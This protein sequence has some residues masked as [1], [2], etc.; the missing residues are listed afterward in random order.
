MARHKSLEA[1]DIHIIYAFSFSNEAVRLS[2]TTN[3][4]TIS[5]IGKVA[6][7]IDNDTYYILIDT[8][9]TWSQ[10]D[11]GG[12]DT[13]LEMS[14]TPSTYTGQAGNV[15]QVNTGAT[16]VEFGQALRTIDSPTFTNLNLTGGIANLVGDFTI[17][18][19]SCL[20]VTSDSDLFL[21]SALGELDLDAITL[22]QITAASG[23]VRIRSQGTTTKI[24][25]TL[26][27]NTSATSFV[28]QDSLNVDLLTV[29]G[30]GKVGIGINSPS[31]KLHVVG[32]AIIS[33]NLTI[34]G[35]T[36]TIDTTTLLV[37]DKNIELGV[38]GTPTDVTADG[39]G[40]TLKGTTD[41]TIIW[42][43]VTDAWQFNQGV[44]VLNEMTIGALT[45]PPTDVSLNLADST[46]AFLVNS[47]TTA[48]RDAITAIEGM[49]YHNLDAN[50][51]EFYN[52]TV[53]QSMG[54]GD[55][56][57]PASSTDNA[58]V[59]FNGTTGKLIQENSGPPAVILDDSRNITGLNNIELTG[60]I[61]GNQ[62]NTVLD[63]V[64]AS[65]AVNNFKISNAITGNNPTIA[66]DGAD[67][68]VSMQFGI[69]GGGDFIFNGNVAI[70]IA[71][72]NTALHVFSDSEVALFESATLDGFV[73]IEASQTP[74][75]QLRTGAV[76]LKYKV[77]MTNTNSAGSYE[78][79]DF[80]N[81]R[82]VFHYDEA[83]SNVGINGQVSVGEDIFS[84][85]D[86]RAL[87]N[88]TNDTF[89]EDLFIDV[90]DS[91][92]TRLRLGQR[93]TAL[94]TN[95][96]AAHII[97]DGNG[98][99]VYSARSTTS[100]STGHFFLTRDGLGVPT[101]RMIL[102]VNGNLG[103][104]VAPIAGFRI[105]TQ[106]GDIGVQG[107]GGSG[108]VKM[109]TGG[110]LSGFGS[111]GT[112]FPTNF[113]L[114]TSNIMRVFVKAGAP[115]V[116]IGGQSPAGVGLA[117][118]GNRILHQGNSQLFHDIFTTTANDAMFRTGTNSVF[119]WAFGQDHS[120]AG[121]FKCQIQRF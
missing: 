33:G 24:I 44:H 10:I 56:V 17:S 4:Y 88:V 41:K 82:S 75:V 79:F 32:S 11:S 53:W 77:G 108:Q 18:A 15:V 5:D 39:G 104:G 118:F 59:R 52:G 80:A 50:D 113:G 9:P 117:V 13:F 102:D 107:V 3:E 68:S 69:K 47:G 110:I 84:T 100:T 19:T 26:G 120:D 73:V 106:D 8:T 37:E 65:G 86:P 74:H 85:P 22:I 31:A 51:L 46:K 91:A 119:T 27:T 2:P 97:V 116:G 36:T 66:V 103:I 20:E 16:A 64:D 71:F 45:A 63:F 111:I 87:L 14:D 83:T 89:L 30:D 7:Q 55:V 1:E 112:S 93:L 21:T 40:I 98:D 38:V 28:V 96:I 49:Q 76:A 6:R 60:L 115:E 92:G 67:A 43:N 70:G 62:G 25:N 101:A 12:F 105:I 114:A 90:R 95:D 34:Q 61:Q 42:E 54:G 23:D 35:T 48:Q 58:L 121:K 29:L 109:E 99:I 78:I 81:T 72:T 94:P 57:G